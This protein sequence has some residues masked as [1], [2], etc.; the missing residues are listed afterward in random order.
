MQQARRDSGHNFRYPSTYVVKSI[1]EQ[2]AILKGFFPKYADA[3]YEASVADSELPVGADGWFAFPR[4]KGNYS[5]KR[6]ALIEAITLVRD[7]GP[8]P[9][10]NIYKGRLNPVYLSQTDEYRQAF[11]RIEHEQDRH[12]ILIIPAQTGLLHQGRSAEQA[13]EHMDPKREF[14]LSPLE[15]AI[16]L[17]THQGRFKHYRDLWIDCP[18][19]HFH[20][21]KRGMQ[22]RDPVGWCLSF[23]LYQGE[24]HFFAR[25][26]VLPHPH[27]GS[28]SGFHVG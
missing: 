9:F 24:T 2:V 12:D 25:R 27:F 10:K 11:A 13:V 18:G 3:T 23:S 20:L 15:V 28:A 14:P 1:E 6:K 7:T 26:P 22:H 19:Y 17:L 5:F 4:E 16:I 8:R 21:L